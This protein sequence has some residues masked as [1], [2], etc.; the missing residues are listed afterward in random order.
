MKLRIDFKRLS[1]LY[2]L[3][4]CMKRHNMPGDIRRSLYFMILGNIFGALYGTVCG[5]GTNT[6]IGLANSLNAGDL[7][8]GI[9]N[10]IPQVTMLLQIPAAMLVNYTHKRKKYM[11][12]FGL[13]SRV[14]WLVIGLVP[15]FVPQSPEGLQMWTVLALLAISSSLS[16]F[17]NCCWFPWLGDLTDP[18][19]RGSWLSTKDSIVS[20]VSVAG[21]LFVAWLLDTLPGNT[22]YAILF[23]FGG[24]FGIIDIISYGF[25]KEVYATAPVKPS[26]KGLFKDIIS[27]KKLVHFM[28]FWAA[29][30]FT[31]NFAGA[32]LNR[33]TINEMGVSYMA[34][35]V[36]GS[37]AS[38]LF[39]ALCIKR[40]GRLISIYGVKPVLWISCAVAAVTQGFFIFA[41]P[42]SPIPLLLHNVIGATFWCGGNLACSQIQ[43]AYPSNENKAASIAVFSC[44]TALAGT[45]LGIMCGGIFLDSME[46]V[47]FTGFWD[48]YKLLTLAAITL[49]VI[50]VIVFMPGVKNETE[51]TVKSMLKDLKRIYIKPRLKKR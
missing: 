1:P 27:N 5:T 12:T 8:F 17:I 19:T 37:I 39:T 15:F 34:V 46:S 14:M 36:C 51:H 32:Y 38:S 35:T 10:A 4:I 3:D 33:Y 31:A 7:M 50:V 16:V 30:C 13:V 48:K 2:S 45:F 9:L 22:K 23:A 41:T 44:F 25:C 18:E 24:G 47:V 42:G 28:V 26:V 6:M 20:V 11:L 49:R 40:W 29:W 21:G 43:L